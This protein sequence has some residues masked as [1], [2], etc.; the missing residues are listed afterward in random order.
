MSKIILKGDICYLESPTKFTKIKSGFLAIN[1]GKIEGVYTKLD[2]SFNDYKLIDY[3]NKLIVPG[4]I[5]THIH[6]P[7]NPFRGIRM[8][9]ELIDWLNK[10]AFCEEQ[11][12]TEEDYYK[13]AYDIFVE[14]LKKSATTR[15][16]IFATIHKDATIYLMQQLEKSGLVTFVGKVNMDRNSPDLLTETT[17]NS[18]FDTAFIVED[19]KNLVNTKPILTPRFTPSCTKELM[20]GLE[21]LQVRYNLPVQSHLSENLEEIELVKSLHP[22]ADFY[23]KT[24]DIYGLFGKSNQNL[25]VK[26]MMAHC[27]WSCEKEQDLMAKNGVFVAHSPLSNLNLSSGI[28][29]IRT[30]LEKGIKVTLATDVAGG[31][32]KSMFSVIVSAIQVSK[33]YWRLVDNTKKPLTFPEAYYMAT[34]VAGEFFQ[35]FSLVGKFEKGYD[36][37]IL[38]LDDSVLPTT[39]DLDID[40]RL[41]RFAYLNGD[42]RQG[43]IYAK[44]VKGVKLF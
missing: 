7:Q 23:A 1:N 11:K 9:D 24:Y 28:A 10:N 40:K 5:D 14:E 32:T 44:F 39:L 8:D 41:E 29:P 43:G 4:L 26:T 27:V 34:A 20:H 22:E 17:E 6:A 38:V 16:S 33:M 42:I 35:D 12:Y 37:D 30:Y 25:P 3:S 13:K 2:S 19:T 18:I 31:H 15:T 21:S 36:A